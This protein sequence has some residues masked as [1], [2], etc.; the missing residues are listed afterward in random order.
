MQLDPLFLSPRLICS[1]FQGSYSDPKS[2][3]GSDPER[4]AKYPYP[5]VYLVLMSKKYQ[6]DIIGNDQ[7]GN[8]TSRIR[9][10]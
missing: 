2:S 4:H 5:H 9:T 1:F 7:V 10:W 6:N 8:F 3:L